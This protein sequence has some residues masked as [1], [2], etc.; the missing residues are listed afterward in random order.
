MTDSTFLHC[1]GLVSFALNEIKFMFTRETCSSLGCCG[2][3]FSRE[4]VWVCT[5]HCEKEQ[6]RFACVPSVGCVCSL[7]LLVPALLCPAAPSRTP[8][9]QGWA[10]LASTHGCALPPPAQGLWLAGA[11]KQPTLTSL[12][13]WVAEVHAALSSVCA[14]T[15]CSREPAN[16]ACLVLGKPLWH[17]T[18]YCET[19]P[20]KQETKSPQRLHEKTYTFF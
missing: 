11:G 16:R 20:C 15:A 5:L 14:G 17:C 9:G 2:R 7:Q 1:R 4:A 18:G 3:L 13:G 6:Q 12:S 8:R 10:L 19:Y